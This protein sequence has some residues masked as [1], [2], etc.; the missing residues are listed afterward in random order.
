MNK[1][2]MDWSKIYHITLHVC[3]PYF[4]KE[5]LSVKTLLLFVHLRL[6]QKRTEKVI[7][8]CQIYSV[9]ISTLLFDSSNH[10]LCSK[11]PPSALTQADRRR[12][13]SSMAWF[14]TDWSS[15]HHTEI[16]RSRS[17]STSFTMLWYTHA[18]CPV[19]Y[20]FLRFQLCKHY[21]NLLRFDRVAVKCTLLRF[22]NHG[23]NVG[24]NFSR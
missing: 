20:I 3:A 15:S 13:H 19:L 14:T 8:S 9:A 12:L 23:K 5:H 11:C 2:Y 22:M 17:S 24:F 18:A 4:V 21:W 1:F 10:K 16:R 7:S 6:Q